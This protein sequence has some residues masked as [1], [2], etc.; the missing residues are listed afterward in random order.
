[1]ETTIILS[2]F[3]SRPAKCNSFLAVYGWRRRQTRKS[4]RGQ[5]HYGYV[6]A[7]DCSRGTS[8][9]RRDNYVF[10]CS[11]SGFQFSSRNTAVRTVRS[12]V[13]RDARVNGKRGGIAHRKKRVFFQTRARYST[14]G[15]WK[16]VNGISIRR[17]SKRKRLAF[18]S[19]VRN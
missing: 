1:M 11:T 19:F 4:T 2:A 3:V 9:K 13:T 18:F 7:I 14:T 10:T 6:N 15:N 12:S 5:Q 8:P 17:K 16:T